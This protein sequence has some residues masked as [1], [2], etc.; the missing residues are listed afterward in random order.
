[1]FSS[2]LISALSIAV[3][4]GHD[5]LDLAGIG[6]KEVAIDYA[7]PGTLRDF[8]R[9]HG[10]VVFVRARTEQWYRIQLNDGCLNNYYGDIRLLIPD[11]GVDRRL[12]QNDLVTI[13][14]RRTCHVESVRT[15][16]PP[17]QVDSKSIVTLD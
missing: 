16:E 14:A 9:G 13:D 6:T 2:L 12:D 11:A 5:Q 8:Q 3:P 17:P 1:M 10:D 4:T 15:S 7:V